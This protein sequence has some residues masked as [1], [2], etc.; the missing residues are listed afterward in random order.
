MHILGEMC[1]IFTLYWVK[2]MVYSFY[3]IL[4]KPFLFVSCGSCTRAVKVHHSSYMHMKYL[5]FVHFKALV[6]SCDFSK[7]SHHQHVCILQLVSSETRF[8]LGRMIVLIVLLTFTMTFEEISCIT[9]K[10]MQS[11]TL[12]RWSVCRLVRMESEYK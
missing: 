10:T 2:I 9:N 8:H 6:T 7:W 5:I 3:I 12:S 4:R 1:H 11:T